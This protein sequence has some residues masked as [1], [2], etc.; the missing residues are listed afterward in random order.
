MSTPASLDDRPPVALSVAIPCYNESAGIDELYTRV[1]K[2]CR[3]HVGQSY[4]LVL[5]NDGSTDTTQ[6]QIFR[7]A[8]TDRHVVAIDLARNY[9]HQT[10]LSAALEFCRG[11]RVLIID[12]DLQDPPELLGEMMAKMDEG[13]DVV[14]GV[15]QEREGESRFKLATASMFYR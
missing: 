7:L 2:V 6:E 14:Y 10:A 13:Y 4:E 12:A 11:R 1:S 9:G 15:R 5:V 3:D 8:E